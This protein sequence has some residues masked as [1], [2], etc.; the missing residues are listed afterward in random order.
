MHLASS[1]CPV[2][3]VNVGVINPGSVDGNSCLGHRRNEE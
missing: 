1:R 2:K 3:T